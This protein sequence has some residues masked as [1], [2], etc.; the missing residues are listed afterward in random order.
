ME[1]PSRDLAEQ[2]LIDERKIYDGTSIEERYH[3][4]LEK[5]VDHLESKAENLPISDVRLSA[6]ELIQSLGE[7]KDGNAYKIE[8]SSEGRWWI[9]HKEIGS[10]EPLRQWLTNIPEPDE[11]F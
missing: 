1:R 6:N 8:P 9:I 10:G 11:E 5:Y 2:Q 7:C 3:N 4:L